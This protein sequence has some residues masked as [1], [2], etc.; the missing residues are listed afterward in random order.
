MSDIKFISSLIKGADAV[1]IFAGAGMGVDSGLEQYRGND[2]LWLKSVRIEGHDVPYYDLMS[3]QAFIENPAKAWALIGEMQEKYKK[4][5]PHE[6]FNLLLDMV[7]NKEYF[8][9]TSNV[10]EHFQK[11]GFDENR[12]F[13]CHG[14]IF[15]MQCTEISERE[16]WLCPEISI[17]NNEFVAL[18]IPKCPECGKNCRPNV[19]L[20][21]DWFWLSTKSAIQQQRFVKWSRIIK[22]SCKNIVAIEIGAGLTINTIRKASEAFTEGT[23]PLVRIN[24]DDAEV[25]SKNH[26]PLA[27][28]AK[29]AIKMIHDA[30]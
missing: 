12:V 18:N 7:K 26:F 6:G 5:T 2:G 28:T 9:V 17:D 10:D 23:F 19:L 8:V 11:A 20:F 14:S 3:H 1:A 25:K 27:M 13:E 15:Y 16:I 30:D 21:G 24:T 29:D 22:E 4:T